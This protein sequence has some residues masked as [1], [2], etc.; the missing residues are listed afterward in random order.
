MMSTT[1][2]CVFPALQN[3]MVSVKV[4]LSFKIKKTTT[5]DRTAEQQTNTLTDQITT[6]KK[7]THTTTKER[8][9]KQLSAQNASVSKNNI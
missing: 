6:N 9:N 8:L 7:D 4:A 2:R 3:E 1:S 5:K